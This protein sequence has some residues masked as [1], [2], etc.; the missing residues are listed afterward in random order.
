MCSRLIW[1]EAE[2]ETFIQYPE[3]NYDLCNHAAEANLETIVNFCKFCSNL[4]GETILVNNF[5]P[6]VFS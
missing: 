4:N 1:H 3:Q 2:C 5:Q 6:E